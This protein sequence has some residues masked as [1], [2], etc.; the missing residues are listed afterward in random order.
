VIPGQLAPGRIHHCYTKQN[1]TNR[2]PAPDKPARAHIALS[3]GGKGKQ[4]GLD[5]VKYVEVRNLLKLGISLD[6]K[7]FKSSSANTTT[8]DPTTT[9]S[10]ALRRAG[11]SQLAP[12]GV[13]SQDAL[14][15]AL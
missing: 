2:Q 4:R 9:L 10:D 15:L 5:S 1:I 12:A 14:A 8:P 7:D 3:K 6:D 13:A 11:I